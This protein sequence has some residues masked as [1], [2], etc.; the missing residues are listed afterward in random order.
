MIIKKD[1]VILKTYLKLFAK[2]GF[3]PA[4]KTDITDTPTT[5]YSELFTWAENC[6]R[7][8][9][10]IE[11]RVIKIYNTDGKLLKLNTV[12]EH[13]EMLRKTMY[14]LYVFMT[15]NIIECYK[16][17]KFYGKFYKDF[18]ST[19]SMLNYNS[20][21]VYKR[22]LNTKKDFTFNEVLLE[23]TQDLL[24]KL[25]FR[26]SVQSS[27]NTFADKSCIKF[28]QSLNDACNFNLTSN[29]H[30]DKKIEDTKTE[31]IRLEALLKSLKAE[32]VK[33]PESILKIIKSFKTLTKPVIFKQIK[34]YKDA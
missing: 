18:N 20:K 31:F 7:I 3:E 9:I 16:S 33:G 19:I 25:L 1:G 32:K 4:L 11:N 14:T 13:S 2:F 17:F 5:T 23:A 21:E 28:V 10:I 6:L 30:E 22:K 12:L 27:N 26:E 8:E 29:F 34:F 15:K 24:N